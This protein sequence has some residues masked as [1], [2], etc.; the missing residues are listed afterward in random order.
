MLLLSA[1][2]SARTLLLI[3]VI[4]VV[5]FVFTLGAR[6]ARRPRSTCS[7]ATS[8][9]S[10]ATS[11]RLWFYLSPA[12]VRIELI[13]DSA[14]FATT[15]PCVRLL[16]AQPVRHPVRVVPGGHLR[17]PGQRPTHARLGRPLGWLGRVRVLL[18][19]FGDAALQARS[20]PCS[21][22]S[23]DGDR[24][25]SRRRSSRPAL[26]AIDVRGPGRPV[27]PP[28]H[29]EDDAPRTRSRSCC[30]ASRPSRVLGAARRVVPARPRRVAG[31][32]RART[33][34]AR[35]R[36]SRSSP[37][38]SCRPRA[39]SRSTAT[40]RACSPSAPASTRT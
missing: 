9:T 27:Q 37:G 40:S 30:R 22:R 10:C 33:A 25:S 16:P 15:R 13:Q 7:T 12:P 18:I 20:S 14:G 2:A 39:W 5:Q 8:A 26:H 28:V 34:R 6:A 38:S 32:H 3:P 36:C 21:R 31:G 19:A 29:Q 1:T 4:A 35:A 17:R 24:P 23:C 11:C